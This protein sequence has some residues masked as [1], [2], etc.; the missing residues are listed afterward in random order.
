MICKLIDIHPNIERTSE[1]KMDFC[2]E[3]TDFRELIHPKKDFR[4][5][6]PEF[7]PHPYYQVFEAKLGFLPNL[8]VIDLL[9]NMGPE[10]LLILQ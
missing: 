2:P 7:I 10:G 8:S 3:E 6:D 9:F 1:Y 4:A 5:V